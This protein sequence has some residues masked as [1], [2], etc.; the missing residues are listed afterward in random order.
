MCTAGGGGLPSLSPPTRSTPV[1]RGSPARFQRRCPPLPRS[2]SRCP[3]ASLPP[4]WARTRGPRR[5]PTPPRG[6]GLGSAGP[7]SPPPRP[8]P[9]L[10]PLPPLVPSHPLPTPRTHRNPNSAASPP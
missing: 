3:P 7:P 9:P 6:S 5:R 10:R 8:P 1:R 4:G 2:R